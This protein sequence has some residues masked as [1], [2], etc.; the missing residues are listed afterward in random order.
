MLVSVDESGNQST[1]DPYPFVI[2]IVIIR[3]EERYKK[4]Y[5]NF[6]GDRIFKYSED[7]PKISNVEGN[8]K[9][10][11]ISFLSARI[12]SIAIIVEKF[13]DIKSLAVDIYGKLVAFHLRK[14]DLKGKV[15]VLYDR[16][17]LLKKDEKL[18]IQNNFHY[19]LKYIKG[20]WISVSFEGKDKDITIFP[21]DYVAGLTRDYELCMEREIKN[22]KYCG[23]IREWIDLLSP[24][25]YFY[26]TSEIREIVRELN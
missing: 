14:I 11:F 12:F 5:H 23:L 18:Y 19:W 20:I 13:E 7:K 21:A 9:G 24:C 22:E 16:N 6:F 1:K 2:G 26:T 25:I 10:E 4:D 15:K 17:P 3:D 8:V